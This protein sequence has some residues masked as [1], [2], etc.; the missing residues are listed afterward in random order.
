MVHI[1]EDIEEVSL[2][3]PLFEQGFDCVE[4]LRHRLRVETFEMR[5]ALLVDGQCCVIGVRGIHTMRH[6]PQPFAELRHEASRGRGELE[7]LAIRR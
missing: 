7:R 2:R 1:L 4:G 6:V 5:R 3:H